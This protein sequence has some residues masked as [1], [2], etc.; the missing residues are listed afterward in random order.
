MTVHVVDAITIVDASD[1]D[2]SC[3]LEVPPVV[4]QDALDSADKIR[5]YLIQR[6]VADEL[7]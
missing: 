4:L 7:C 6:K 2:Y 1:S 5:H 3:D